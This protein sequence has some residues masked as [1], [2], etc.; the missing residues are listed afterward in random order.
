M[1]SITIAPMETHAIAGATGCPVC[2]AGKSSTIYPRA[3]D[4][5]TLDFFQVCRCS[6]CGVAYTA[7]RPASMDRYYPAQYRAYGPLVRGVLRAL[8]GLRVSRWAKYK[9]GGGKVLEIG[10]GPG[11]MLEEFS[12]RGWQA[13][14]VERNDAAA[15]EARGRVGAAAIFTR[16][17]DVPAGAQF[18]LI[19]MFQVL[20]HIGEPV[21]LLQEC[22]QRLAREGRLIINVPNFSSWQ[23][24]W[25]GAKWMHLDVPRHL[26]HFTPE[27]MAATLQRSGLKVRSI[28]FASPEHDPYGWIESS[29][30]RTSGRLHTIT[31]FLMG[32]DP[33]GPR[34][35]LASLAGGVL[36]A[37]ALF[38]SAASWLTG[39]G[40]L[41][42][43]V[44]VNSSTAK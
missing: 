14:G 25:A 8:Y 4:P 30:S 17:E 22:S 24:R 41:M 23:S 33:L 9:K 15:A 13:F 21:S 20:E 39:N 42:E 5:I 16:L 12:R 26:V 43:I 38:L 1:P 7:P 40:A 28:G 37:P 44:A 2:G 32:L 11:L 10:C 6:G 31:R 27:S 3:Q 18:D 29:V 19:V 35:F 34:V 36:L